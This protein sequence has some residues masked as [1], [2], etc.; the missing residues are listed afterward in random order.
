MKSNRE[1][2]G[3]EPG[4]LGELTGNLRAGG[5]AVVGVLGDALKGDPTA[6]ETYAANG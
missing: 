1:F 5:S 2:F 6:H 3:S 4:N